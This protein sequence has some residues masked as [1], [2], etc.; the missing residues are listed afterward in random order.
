MSYVYQ[1]WPAWRW[2]PSGEGKIF[3]CAEDVPEGWGD[4]PPAPDAPAEP[5]Q[6]ADPEA[7]EAQCRE[8]RADADRASDLVAKFQTERDKLV[9]GLAELGI[10]VGPD[11]SPAAVALAALRARDSA[12]DVAEEGAG[13]QDDIAALREAYRER[14]GTKPFM[15]WDVEALKAKMADA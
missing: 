14:F 13:E 3:E 1:A 12:A 11:D 10:E 5:A 6:G 2:G 4:T 9:E 7:L 8:A 15:G